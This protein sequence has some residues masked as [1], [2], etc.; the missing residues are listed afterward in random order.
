M[1]LSFNVRRSGLAKLYV[2]VGMHPPPHPPPLDPPLSAGVEQQHA[3]SHALLH[4][5]CVTGDSFQRSAA[6]DCITTY[7]IDPL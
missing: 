6:T 1:I 4:I 5:S 3:T 7:D 2:P